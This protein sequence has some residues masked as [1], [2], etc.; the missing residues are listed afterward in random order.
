MKEIIN[1]LCKKIK[2]EIQ[3][4]KVLKNN[5][6]KQDE[7]LLTLAESIAEI[8]EV[9][10]EIKDTNYK[11]FYIDEHQRYKELEKEVRKLRK[12]VKNNEKSIRK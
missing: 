8:R 10:E 7:L 4:K 1:L 3:V 12:E 6:Y 11:N 5:L 2:T 9:V